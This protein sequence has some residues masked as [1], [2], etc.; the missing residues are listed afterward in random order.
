MRGEETLRPIGLLAQPKK[1][2]REWT[3]IR[4]DE[5]SAVVGETK[6]DAIRAV[7]EMY[8]PLLPRER[9]SSRPTRA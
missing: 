2:P 3:L 1:A 8:A 7:K 4:P 9:R 5:E 6:L